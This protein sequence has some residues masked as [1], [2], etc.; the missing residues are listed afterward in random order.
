MMNFTLTN[1]TLTNG[2]EIVVETTA[3][4]MMAKKSG[5]EI[6]EENA[7]EVITFTKGVSSQQYYE[8][9]THQSSWKISHGYSK[10]NHNSRQ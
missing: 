5:A 1:L 10:F 6:F 3:M 4:A 7:Y 8:S 2:T 9:M